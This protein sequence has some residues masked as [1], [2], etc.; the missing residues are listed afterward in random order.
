MVKKLKYRPFKHISVLF[1]ILYTAY[2]VTNILV[3]PK[4]RYVAKVSSQINNDAFTS[5]IGEEK[6]S[7]VRL[8]D[9]SLAA[10]KFIISKVACL[11]LLNHFDAALVAYRLS[12]HAPPPSRLLRDKQFSFLAYQNFRI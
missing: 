8:M 2:A 12:N 6:K 1:L 4:A 10:Q 9:R 7:T 5:H 11:E 3:L